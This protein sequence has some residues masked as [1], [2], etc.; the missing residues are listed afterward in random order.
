LVAALRSGF[1]GGRGAGN[2][3][4]GAGD[5]NVIIRADVVLDERGLRL[6]GDAAAGFAVVGIFIGNGILGPGATRRE[7]GESGGE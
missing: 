6:D 7:D 4:E 2:G 1:A 3:V 5:T